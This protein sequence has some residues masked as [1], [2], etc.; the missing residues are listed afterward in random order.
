[1]KT[2]VLT[3]LIRSFV[4]LALFNLYPL[5][6]LAQTYAP[7]TYR[8][9]V[10]LIVDKTIAVDPDVS[11]KIQRLID[12][13]TG[14]GWRVLR[15]DV[16]RGPEFQNLPSL[17]EIQTWKQINGPRV[18]EI[19]ALIQ[20]DYN[21]A[22]NE[23]KNVL[24]IGH[25]PV[26][27]SGTTGFNG[28]HYAGAQPADAFY[29]E[30]TGWYGAGGWSDTATQVDALTSAPW[31]PQALN[32]PQDGVFD[33]DTLPAPMKLGV[34][35]VDLSYVRESDFGVNEATLI[36]RYLDKDH[37]FRCSNFSV[38]RR[39]IVVGEPLD[40]PTQAY[41]DVF[42]S[43]NVLD[44]FTTFSWFPNVSASGQ[45]YLVGDGSAHS[46]GNGNGYVGSEAQS[47]PN[48]FLSSDSRV[49]FVN[50][51]GS[52]FG[53]WEEGVF[54]KAPLANPYDPANG[55]YGYGLTCV[56]HLLGLDEASLTKRQL[57][58]TIG[59]ALFVGTTEDSPG[60]NPLSV[61]N[62]L[63]GDPTLRMHSV[64]E[65][66]ALTAVNNGATVTLN[67]T[68]SA[69][70]AV[71][72]YNVYSA[73]TRKGPYILVNTAGPITA[74]T[75]TATR[76]G[77]GSAPDNFYMIRA[78]KPETT[79]VG[80]YVNMAEGI[81]T[82]VPGALT[83]YLSIIAQPVSQTVAVHTKDGIANSVVFTVDAVGCDTAGSQQIIYQ[84]YNASGPLSDDC[85]FKGVNTS[86]L[87][88]SGLQTSDAGNYHV[89]V[90][91]L[92]PNGGQ[93]GTVS[94]TSSTATLTISD[95]PTAV[96]D[97][98]SVIRNTPS[99]FNVLANDTDPDTANS[100]LTVISVSAPSVAAAGTLTINPDQRTIHFTPAVSWLGQFTFTYLVFDGTTADQGTVTVTV[101]PTPGDTITVSSIADQQMNEDS[102]TTLD[103][104]FT[105][106]DTYTP[107]DNL[108]YVATCSTA[109]IPNANFSVTGTGNN[110]VLHILAG[111]H[112]AGSGTVTLTATDYDLQSATVSFQ[113]TINPQN[114]PT[115]L[116]TGLQ[117]DG[118]HITVNGPANSQFEIMASADLRTWV[119]LGSFTFNGDLYSFVDS[120]AGSFSHR[121]YRA[122]SQ[123]GSSVNTIG[124][125]NI[126]LPASK[127][128]AVANQLNNPAGNTLAVILAGLPNG[129]IVDTWNLAGQGYNTA[130]K[131]RFNG[132]GSHT[133]MTLNPGVGALIECPSAQTLTFVG[134]V[135]QGQQVNSGFP[136]VVGN[137]A[138]LG[139]MLP[140]TGTLDS[141]GFPAR[142]GDE[143]MQFDLPSQ[144]WVNTETYNGTA[145]LPTSP[146][147]QEATIQIGEPFFLQSG[148]ATAR[149]WTEN[150]PACTPA[151]SGI[152]SWWPAEGN[153]DDI[154]G[155]NNGAPVGN[156][157]YASGEVGQ[158][159]VFD[160]STSYIPLASSPSLDVGSGTGFTI[161][162]W[163]L[164]ASGTTAP[165]VE[166]D[167]SS[168]DGLQFWVNNGTQL[169]ANLKDTSGGDH[170]LSSASGV[171]NNAGFQHV[172]LTY[173]Q[174]SGNAYMYLNGAIVAS[175]N[176]GNI[177]PQTSYQ[178]YNLNIG[179]RTGQPVGL[180]DTY[181]GL[182]DELSIYGRAL[183]QSE[184]SAI[185]VAGSLGKC[186]TPPPC[187][188][189]P[190]G[191]VGWW[192]A[193]GNTDDTIGGN[194]GTING[195]VTYSS[196]EV[197]QSFLFDGSSGYVSIPA[198][199]SLDV[200]SGSG[201]TI[202]CWIWPNN[203]G[204]GDAQPIVEWDDPDTVGVQLWLEN[205][206]TL[207]GNLRDASGTDYMMESAAGTINT[208]GWQHVAETYDQA[209]G[210]AYLYINGVQVA[211]A[212]FGT[213]TP[214][215]SLPLYFGTRAAQ[216]Y[217]G[218][219]DL[220][221]GGL[222]EVSIYNRA[223]SPS[224]ISAIYAAGHSGKC[225]Q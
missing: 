90:S 17:G 171:L 225:S 64:Q 32:Y 221:S 56:Y 66:G 91:N 51:Y 70:Q 106:T 42:G 69:D 128:V 48:D 219:G 186:F 6:L 215:T 20:A 68:A 175:A 205:P 79:P 202:E 22:P 23:V 83:P 57:G 172:A 92:K 121:F 160:G 189:V 132:W 4:F 199:S 204:P 177:T 138:M 151:P 114:V 78:I 120:A 5:H 33:Q 109:L 10:V 145:W 170:T 31:I 113:I 115:L 158:A 39:G 107:A 152:I 15:H 188:P 110:R 71:T 214:N 224:E 11:P 195:G 82:A 194:N 99:D 45:D 154:I 13:L 153:A 156:L 203:L 164:P 108:Q 89:V 63:M 65:A 178:D 47:P 1:M 30:M 210:N 157:T 197:G 103:I 58:A 74:T 34:G 123:N 179:R 185:Y 12:D 40:D 119:P 216:G 75:Y 166:W 131:T 149:S 67:W 135:P 134:D 184:I 9:K 59:E 88:I 125:I 102:T 86:S 155:G 94:I 28:G 198:S 87:L 137:L 2:R 21:S 206:Y 85:H 61:N 101:N 24:L 200:G 97:T 150:G 80:S 46:G 191:I 182:L 130:R 213:I 93:S 133:G 169:Y 136:T 142:A 143:I 112:E 96:N 211:S 139:S 117:Q 14:D 3:H 50:L 180:N 105:V 118:F 183:S 126:A 27:Y 192:P 174:A 44:D 41:Q 36:S 190:S 173:D 81:I 98:Y 129:T 168:S 54:L 140:L 26:P 201:M 196:G 165:I 146:A 29:G 212:N 208:T 53:N 55:R 163:I 7:P 223:L 95:P 62:S 144:Q 52:W 8:G 147:T 187:D 84:W 127:L 122:T 209:S 77:T 16:D 141:M 218:S 207:F 167:S 159:F 18:R 220:Y 72:G 49:V 116:P 38:Q 176:F 35:R 161:E 100:A 193:E 162:G 217:P 148:S 19:R 25:V 43:A 111:T 104:P 73:P 222:D 37:D 124:F 60:G 181:Q 76:P